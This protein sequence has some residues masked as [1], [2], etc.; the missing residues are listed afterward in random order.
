[1]KVAC[2]NCGA[3]HSL[4]DTRL[5]RLA[6]VQFN[7]AKCGKATLVNLTQRPDATR[8]MSP[9]PQFARSAGAPHLTRYAAAPETSLRLPEG[10]AIALSIIAGPARGQLYAMDKPR[11]VLGRADADMTIDD[12]QVSRWHCAIETKD[13][14]I[15]L[16]DLESTNGTFVGDERV[17]VAVLK[18]LSEFRVGMSTILV[19]VTPRLA[20]LN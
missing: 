20:N 5:V 4:P 17:R 18:H 15:T 11:I 10:K 3:Q 13:D 19:S 2:S 8:A 6:R 7:C 1:M 16:R 9:V 12:D 14:A